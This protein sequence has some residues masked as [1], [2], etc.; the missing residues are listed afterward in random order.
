MVDLFTANPEQKFTFGLW[1]IGNVGRDP[2]SEPV[3]VKLTPVEIVYK[4]AEAGVYGVNLH[5]H[6][7]IPIGAA[8]GKRGWAYEHLDQITA[9]LLL[10]V[11]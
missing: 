9:E 6:D 3:R 1:T 11:H 7:L 4:L 10:G 5:D 8:Q 2:I